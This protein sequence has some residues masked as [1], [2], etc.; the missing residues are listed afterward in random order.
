LGRTKGTTLVGAVRFLRSKREEARRVLPEHLHGYL[1]EKVSLSAWYP[2]DDLIGLIRAMLALIP[3]PRGEALQMMGRVTAREH[4]DGIYS[5]LMKEGATTTSSFALWSSQHDTGKLRVTR[6]G[7][8]VIRADLV[9]YENPSHEMCAIIEAYVVETVR[10]SGVTVS[11]KKIACQ[12]SGD[13]YC[14][15]RCSLVGAGAPDVGSPPDRGEGHS[16]PAF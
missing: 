6:E 3:G 4:H 7:S 14:S 10:L 2:E 9:G 8:K 5:H 15:W 12:L 13:E 1:H 11:A 16:D